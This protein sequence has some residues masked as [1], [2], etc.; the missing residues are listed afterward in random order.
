MKKLGLGAAATVAALMAGAS[1]AAEAQVLDG[2][3]Y[4]H[5]G[6]AQLALADEATMSLGG[7]VIPGATY[8]SDPQTTAVVEIG[9]QLS[10]HW[11]A[12]ITV[13]APPK[14]DAEAAGSIAGM[15]LLGSAT[16]GPM[17]ITT[18]YHFNPEGRFQPYVG[19]GVSYMHVFNT[20]DGVMNNLEVDNTF[21]P[22]WQ[23]GAEYQVNEVWNMFVDVK[24]AYLETDARGTIGGAPVMADMVF[25]PFVVN[26]GVGYR[27]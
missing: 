14:A 11:A 2:N 21:G 20:S 26:L 22:V 16:Y 4:V 25:D 10:D 3:W 27:F 1:E 18:H 24:Q 13:G 12:S 23:V 7:A 8:S 19:A 5:A 6:P 15:G 9:R 17:A